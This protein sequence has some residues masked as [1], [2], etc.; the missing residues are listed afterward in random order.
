M[1]CNFVCDC[2]PF[3]DHAINVT[4][5]SKLKDRAAAEHILNV[6]MFHEPFLCS[7]NWSNGQ[8]MTHSIIANIYFRNKK[9]D[10]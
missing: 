10:D 8:S 6:M 2:F 5:S 9:K 4:T 7:V 1:S 3:I